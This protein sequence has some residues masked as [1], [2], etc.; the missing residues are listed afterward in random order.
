[1]TSIYEYD[2]L[3]VGNP[4]SWHQSLRAAIPGGSQGIYRESYSATATRGIRVRSSFSVITG[5]DANAMISWTQTVT[6]KQDQTVYEQHAYPGAQPIAVQLP[7]TLG[8]IIQRGQR[9]GR[10]PVD[11]SPFADPHRPDRDPG[12][13]L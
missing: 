10:R 11:R 13:C 7:T 1:M 6:V 3:I 4:M 12:D 2:Y 9:H 8:S 5:A